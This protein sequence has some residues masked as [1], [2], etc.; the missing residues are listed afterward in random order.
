MVNNV[1]SHNSMGG[2]V[3]SAA[4]SSKMVLGSRPDWGGVSYSTGLK[5]PSEIN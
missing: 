1:A 2:A 3:V 5:H 4:A